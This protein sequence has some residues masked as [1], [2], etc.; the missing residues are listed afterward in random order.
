MT[1][2]VILFFTKI[3]GR[4]LPDLLAKCDLAVDDSE[5]MG[6]AA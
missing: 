2:F 6:C 1:C 5:I 3:A 4:L